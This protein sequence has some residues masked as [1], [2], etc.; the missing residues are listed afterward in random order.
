MGVLLS[1]E[2]VHARQ[3]LQGP[4]ARGGTRC[5]VGGGL[6]QVVRHAREASEEE[7]FIAAV[8]ASPSLGQWVEGGA[9]VEKALP[10][11]LGSG[12][13]PRSG[14]VSASRGRRCGRTS[15][16]RKRR[17]PKRSGGATATRASSGLRLRRSVEARLGRTIRIALPRPRRLLV[18]RASR[19]RE[20]AT[21]V[22]VPSMAPALRASRQQPG[23]GI[24]MIDG[25]WLP[26]PVASNRCEN[27]PAPS[28]LWPSMCSATVLTWPSTQRIFTPSGFCV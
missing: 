10:V 18:H 13:S 19:P 24:L 17:R 20:T 16:R 2:A 8:A 22:A 1:A 27:R 23:E 28:S 9:F 15:E 14:L 11:V 4:P 3:R 26:R 6:S 21:T 12:C 5:F 7:A 25:N